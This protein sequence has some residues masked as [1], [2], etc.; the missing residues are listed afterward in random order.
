MCLIFRLWRGRLLSDLKEE[1]STNVSYKV[2]V[3]SETWGC[4]L[5]VKALACEVD[6]SSAVFVRISA[7]LLSLYYARDMNWIV[8]WSFWLSASAAGE[9]TEVILPRLASLILYFSG[10]SMFKHLDPIRKL[11][12]LQCIY[13]FNFIRISGMSFLLLWHNVSIQNVNR[14]RNKR[15]HREQ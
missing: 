7:H 5:G 15:T 8:Q 4:V 12:L 3:N 11:K 14:A 13:R 6:M 10:F 1:E 2:S 9:C